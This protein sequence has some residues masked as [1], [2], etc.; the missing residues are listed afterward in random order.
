[1]RSEPIMRSEPNQRCIRLDREERLLLLESSELSAVLRQRLTTDSA[2][3]VDLWFSL[4]EADDLRELAQD[5]LQVHG[6]DEHYHPTP[7]GR[8]L[9]QLIDKLFTG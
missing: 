8:A 6:F 3:P 9:E 4:D 1:M 7:K 5:M 2:R